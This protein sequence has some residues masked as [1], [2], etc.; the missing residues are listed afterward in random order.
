MAGG[1]GIEPG[2]VRRALLLGM[3]LF[4]AFVVAGGG[5]WW[6][7]M[8]LGLSRIAAFLVAVIA[9]PALVGGVTL[10]WLLSLPLERRQRV[11]GVTV[12]RAGD[13]PD[14]AGAA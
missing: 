5:L 3:V 4:A 7:G 2:G 1:A 6:V 13:P 9:G 8:A 14:G 11:L 10:L 12:R